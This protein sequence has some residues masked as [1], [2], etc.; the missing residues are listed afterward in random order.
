M[1]PQN[2]MTCRGDR[3]RRSFSLIA[4]TK[5]D[6]RL[7]SHN[8]AAA[9]HYSC[10]HVKTM[11]WRNQT[12]VYCVLD[13]P[14][15]RR[16]ICIDWWYACSLK[17]WYIWFSCKQISWPSPP[18]I[19]ATWPEPFVACHTPG[20]CSV[21]ASARTRVHGHHT[22]GQCEDHTKSCSQ[23]QSVLFSSI[24]VCVTNNN[25]ACSIL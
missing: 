16:I 2:A 20:S 3:L 8:V 23:T 9:A 15:R 22:A 17:I 7:S 24:G 18:I 12:V 10:S 25:Y 11:K 21:L 5:Q 14:W 1:S 4:M 13:D 6:T 19:L